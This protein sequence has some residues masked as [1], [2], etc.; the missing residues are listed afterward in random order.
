[1]LRS[2]FK[3]IFDTVDVDGNGFVLDS[4]KMRATANGI[5]RKMLEADS[6]K[7]SKTEVDALIRSGIELARGLH[8]TSVKGY[9]FDDLFA[10]IKQWHF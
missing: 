2:V 4:M 7:F 6:K 9:S 10:V 5:A 1:M 8:P 3:R